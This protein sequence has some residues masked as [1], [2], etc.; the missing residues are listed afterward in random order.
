MASEVFQLAL[1]L[2]LKD[3]ASAGLDRFGAK[4][5]GVDR[6]SGKFHSEFQKIRDDLN[7]DVGIGAVGATGLALLKKGVDTAG[8]YEATLVDLKSAYAE[9]NAQGARSADQQKQDFKEL[10]TLATR[11]GSDL[12]GSTSDYVKILT[13]MKKAGIDTETVLSG[14]GEAAAHLANINKTIGTPLAAEGA[15]ELGQYGKMFDLKTSEYKAAVNL[16]SALQDRFDVGSGELVEGSKYFASTAKTAMDLRGYE[17][18]AQVAKLIAFSK[19][20]TG[21]EGS[22]SGTNLDAIITQ[23]VQH[24]EA[25]KALEQKSGIKLDFFD[26]KGKFKGETADQRVETLFREMEKLRALNPRERLE[27]LNSIFGV[28]GGRIAGQMVEQGVAGWKSVSEEAAKAVPVNEKII[29]QMATYNAKTEALAGSWENFK[30]TAFTPLMESSKGFLDFGSKAVNALQQFSAEHPK[31]MGGLGTLA[32]Y[33]STAMVVYGGF[34]TLTTGVKMFRLA[35]A[36]SR[37]EGLLP[38]LR[39]TATAANVASTSMATATSRS[40]GLKA[41][42]LGIGRSGPVRIGVHIASIMGLEAAVS[43]AIQKTI[44]ATDARTGAKAAIDAGASSYRTFMQDPSV[45]RDIK[46]R[47]TASHTRTVF[48]TLNADNDLLQTLGVAKP[49]GT[50]EFLADQFKS[51]VFMYPFGGDSGWTSGNR[52]YDRGKA[53][54]RFRDQAPSLANPEVMRE[55]LRLIPEKVPGRDAPSI[56]ARE[57]LN[58]VARTAFPESYA[59]AIAGMQKASDQMINMFSSLQQPMQGTA[60]LFSGL[61]PAMQPVS[62][63]FANLPMPMQ[64][65]TQEFTNLPQPMNQTRSSLVEVY[66]A[67]NRVPPALNNIALSVSTVAGSLDG[68]SSKIASWQPPASPSGPATAPQ[69][70]QPLFSVPGRS[71]GGVVERSGLAMVHAG[72][73]ITPAGVTRGLGGFSELMALARERRSQPETESVSTSYQVNNFYSSVPAGGTTTRVPGAAVGAQVL[74]SG[75][76]MIHADEEVVP[77]RVRPFRDQLS[78]SLTRSLTQIREVERER[79]VRRDPLG[80]ARTSLIDRRSSL[81]NSDT[82]NNIMSFMQT[83]E[84]ERSSDAV[85]EVTSQAFASPVDRRISEHSELE[86]YIRETLT[87]PPIREAEPGRDVLRESFLTRVAERMLATSSN[88]ELASI[89]TE[90]ERV[91]AAPVAPDARPDIGQRISSY[92]DLTRTMTLNE[93]EMRQSFFN[94]VGGASINELT[95]I[96]S[97]NATRSPGPVLRADSPLSRPLNP[98]TGGV[99]DRPFNPAVSPARREGVAAIAAMRTPAGREPSLGRYPSPQPLSPGPGGVASMVE[100]LTNPSIGESLNLEA[101][102]AAPGLASGGTQSEIRPISVS[103]REGDIS[104]TMTGGKNEAARIEAIMAR[105][106]EETRRM[107]PKLAVEAVTKEMERGRQRT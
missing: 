88:R 10:S 67:A 103:I 102:S 58:T 25:V 79:E 1:L 38:Y 26:D 17:G 5:R 51:S 97:N 16:F 92:I 27:T 11:L 75:L 68:L 18:A 60:E 107:I 49:R 62:Q 15:K 43:Y 81:E 101:A 50:Y 82:T 30:A 54:Q 22:R 52:N 56:R 69:P 66:N 85:R 40:K 33:G 32:L 96:T 105:H 44:E 9:T 6:D 98:T 99:A 57:E 37:G 83:R 73:V 93:S 65:V 23:F 7:R 87:G 64:S 71:V 47:E 48:A 8:D 86:S 53:T 77:A 14:A 94:S 106:R 36:F 100:I 46:G 34:K 95:S 28:E 72:N 80:Q 29:A 13:A 63:E 76:A 41:G 20:Y 70:G 104:I 55:F 45:P 4:L 12:Q 19:R 90:R 89:I 59:E 31:L 74:G 21:Y 91:G 78:Q 39:Q 84:I 35:A 61:P 3:Q 24:P 42:L 2:T